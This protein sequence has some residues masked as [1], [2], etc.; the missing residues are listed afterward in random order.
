ME[1]V[2][3]SMMTWEKKVEAAYKRLLSIPE[4]VDRRV[5]EIIERVKDQ[6]DKALFEYTRL[7]DD[8]D[9]VESG[10]YVDEDAIASSVSNVPGDLLDALKDAAS[11]IKAF[12]EK[13]METSWFVIDEAGTFLG[14]KV[15]PIPRVGIYVPGGR[16]AFP[17]TLLMNVIPARIAG[18]EEIVVVSPTPGGLLNPAL[19]AAAYVSGVGKIYRVGGAQAVA[20]LVHGTESIPKVDKVVGPGNIYVSHAKRLLN[21]LV[22]ID[23]IAGP[24]EILVIADKDA[25]PR[26]V[27]IDLLSQAEHDPMACAFLLTPEQSLAEEVIEAIDEEVMTLPRKDIVFQSLGEHGLCVVTKDMDEAIDISNKIAPEHLELMVK[28]A[29]VYLGKVK[30]AGAVFLGYN[31]PEVTGDYVAGPNHTLPT[32]STARFSSPLGVYDFV[33]RTSVISLTKDSL[34]RLGPTASIIARAESLD[35]HARSVEYRLRK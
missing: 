6:G 33:K 26:L 15:Q 16:N 25:D 22:G 18:V 12:H 21:G 14:Q 1:I 19:L 5:R 11:R 23:S 27:A 28:D 31:T 17:S 20:A 30:N 4:D 3:T 7:F 34:Y 32:G 10:I 29:Y 8:Y 2:K 24:S 9:P 35:A 13:E